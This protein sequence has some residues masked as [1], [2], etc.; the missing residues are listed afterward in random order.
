M[1]VLRLPGSTNSSH[2]NIAGIDGIRAFAAFGVVLLHACV[3]YLQHPMPGLAW[4]VSDSSSVVVDLLFW[5]IEL[6]IMPLFLAL[7]GILACRTLKQRGAGT[8]LRTRARRLLLPLAFGMVVILPLDLYAWLSGWVTEGLIDPIKLRSLKFDG[9]IDQHL[10]GLSHLWFL[11]YLFLYVAG[12]ALWAT[13]R[14]KFAVLEHLQPRFQQSVAV[15]LCIAIGTLFLSP[16]VV[17][18]FQHAFYPVP[19][20]F[21]HSGT[22]FLGGF[23]I[24]Q[25]DPELNWLCVAT[26]RMVIPTVLLAASAVTLGRWHLANETNQ[27]AQ[28]SLVAVTALAA[29]GLTLSSIGMAIR[30]MHR[31]PTA[32]AYLAAGSFW[33]YLVH[34]PILGLI[35]TDLKWLMPGSSPAL[36]TGIAF[37]VC[38]SYSLL[39][40]EGLVRKTRLGSLLGMAWQPTRSNLP[41][42]APPILPT[43]RIA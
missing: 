24:A 7:A 29:W 37:V 32:I 35:H 26:R 43:R 14:S 40:Y 20:K 5:T 21:I 36:K 23:V 10:W 2:T 31:V 30:N 13:V 38:F 6:F 19:S 3:P 33:V 16:E 9:V 25:H 34:H 41:A 12:V 39:T 8:L 22:F 18:G 28:L 15:L 27:L 17:W 4:S 1:N 42:Q 11:Q